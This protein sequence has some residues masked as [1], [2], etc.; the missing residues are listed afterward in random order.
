MPVLQ[1]Q[2][3]ASA[4]LA[5]ASR[6]G[7]VVQAQDERTGLVFNAAFDPSL[8]RYDQD[9]ENEQACSAV[10]QS[11]LDDVATI[12]ARH[13]TDKR[14]IEVGCGKGSFLEHL[15]KVGY[16]ITG[17]DPAYEG[18]NPDVIKAPFERGLGLSADGIILPQVLE[19]IADAVTF[20]SDVAAANGGQGLIYIE[21]PSFN[22]ILNRRTW[23]DIV[24][25]HVNYFRVLDFER[26]FG[27]IEEHGSLI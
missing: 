10:F 9:Y 23:F 27:R 8:L 7:D 15:R 4:T 3:F 26:M 24:D 14:L 19:H 12:V 13:F 21:V 20:L 1:N 2:T 6:T 5:K 25:E 11:P 18:D 22:W 17:I 16:D